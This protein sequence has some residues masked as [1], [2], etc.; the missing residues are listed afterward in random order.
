MY[1]EYHITMD[2]FGKERP[3]NWQEIADYLNNIIDE[4][5]TPDEYGN[6][7]EDDKNTLCKIWEDYWNEN[8]QDAP[9]P[10]A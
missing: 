8:M 4:R 10:I 1:T 3:E 6:I 7:T 2:S 9:K 5:V